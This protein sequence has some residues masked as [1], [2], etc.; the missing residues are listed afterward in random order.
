[1]TKMDMPSAVELVAAATSTHTLFEA[2]QAAGFTRAEALAL[3]RDAIRPV[4]VPQ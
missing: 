4:G 3:V 1:M 2:F